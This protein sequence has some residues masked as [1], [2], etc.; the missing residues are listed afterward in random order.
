MYEEHLAAMAQL[1]QWAEAAGHADDA[2]WRAA[3]AIPVAAG[4]HL[5][6][7]RH[8][9]LLGEPAAVALGTMLCSHRRI[10]CLSASSPVVCHPKKFKQG[11][12]LRAQRRA[13]SR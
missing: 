4:G 3:G 1:W 2:N 12:A 10:A 8:L 13:C 6:V 9:E 11:I 7:G 5:A